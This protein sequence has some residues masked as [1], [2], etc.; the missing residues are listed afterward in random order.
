MTALCLNRRIGLIARL[1]TATKRALEQEGRVAK[2]PA[3]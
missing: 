2:D 3:P 1:S